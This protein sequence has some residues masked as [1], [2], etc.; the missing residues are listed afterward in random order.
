MRSVLLATLLLLLGGGSAAAQEA[1]CVLAWAPDGDTVHCEDGRKIRLIGIDTPERSQADFGERARAHLLRLAPKGTRLSVHR[2]VQPREPRKAGRTPRL[3]AY[4]G[5]P[6]GRMLN[7][8]MVID[9]Y[10]TLLTI[11]PNVK[12]A[13]RLRAAQASARKAG[14]GLWATHAFDC[15]PAD[16][17][18]GRCTTPPAGEMR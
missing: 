1:P 12:H 2:D 15:P 17:R 14:R 7:E 8:Q 3:L 13:G 4:L 5:L 9:G 10:A 6:D 18:R 11:P 16:F